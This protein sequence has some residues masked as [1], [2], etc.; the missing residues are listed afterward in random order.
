MSPWLFFPLLAWPLL[1]WQTV[2]YVE[3]G[4]KALD[5]QKNDE[6]AALFQKAVD[7]DPKDYAAHFHLALADS[8]LQRDPQAIAEY[9]RTLEL[10]PNLYEADLNLGILYLRGKYAADAAPML[11]AAVAQKPAE[12]RPNYFL[13]EALLLVGSP[14]QAQTHFEAALKANP[15]SA[16]AELGLG[17]ALLAQKQLPAAEPHFRSAAELDP[18]DRDALL[19]LASA[20]EKAGRVPEAIAIYQQFPA[21]GAAQARLGELLLENKQFADAIPR[22]E[23]AVAD[24]PTVA[25]RLALAT[26]YGMNKQPE[27]QDEQLDKAVASEPGNYDL[28]MIY[29]RQLRDER[30]LVPAANQFLAAAKVKPDSKESWDELANVLIVHGD[31]TQGLAALEK[32]R[33][34][35]A[36]IPGDVWLRAITLDKIHQK[37]LALDSYKQFLAL[38]TGKFPDQEFQARQRIRILET[39]LHKR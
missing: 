22:L 36:E 39:E 16:A 15:K 29:G 32:R 24:S 11:Q 1:A 12:Y 4:R 13:A 19:E 8:L 20:E 9:K 35:G 27:K 10:K 25:N 18:N 14:D 2:D 3:Q 21:N 5:A 31:L 26:A 34:L 6:A 38:S 23:K 17:H 37:P 33:A 28:R 7:A 30:K